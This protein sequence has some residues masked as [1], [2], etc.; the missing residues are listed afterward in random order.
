MWRERVSMPVIMPVP[1]KQ[2][3]RICNANTFEGISLSALVSR[4]VC[5]ILESRLSMVEEQGFI[6]EE[7]G[8]FHK[9]RRCRDQLL[10]LV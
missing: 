8:G 7:Q 5:R 2:A 4:M 3:R 6:I 1:K 10:S 9:K